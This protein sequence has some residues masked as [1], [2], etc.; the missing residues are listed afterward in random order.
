MSR[1][2]PLRG[3]DAGAEMSMQKWLL[4]E[5]IE[6]L[7]PG[8][9]ARVERLRRRILDLFFTHGYELV[10]PPMLEY[11]ESLLTGTGHDLD[12]KTF[13]LVDQLSGRLLGLRADITPQV[14]RIDAHLLNRQGVTRLCYAGT[15]LH[16]QPSGLLRTREPMQIG[17]ELYGHG[18]LESDIEI[19]ML[20]LRAL[21]A[22]GVEGV[23]LDIGHVSVFRSLITHAGVTAQQ[24]AELFQ[25]LQ[26]KDVP[27]LRD[28]SRGLDAPTRT[29]LLLLPDLYGGPE[30]LAMARERLPR[31]P[32]LT[33]CLD[34]LARL[35][36]ELRADV[37]ELCFDLAELRGYHYHS[38][39]VFAA[40]AGNQ[41]EAIARGGRYDEVGRAFGRARA[42]T[43]FTMD[44]R[45]LAQIGNSREQPMRV[46][47]PHRPEDAALQAE[48]AK[49]R[50]QGVVVVPD[51]PG[52]DT[53]R[54]ELDCTQELVEKNATWRLEKFD[55]T[56]QVKSMQGNER[57]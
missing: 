27:A 45:E 30:V 20:M 39:V 5:Y 38:G 37:N 31:Y 54:A 41:P 42:A 43:G 50:S 18:G 9:A 40:Y 4:P 2:E 53:S 24:E 7:L 33:A 51:L 57:S 21:Q 48:I 47:A 46:L 17:A 10:V 25:V 49:L 56:R 14:A 35:G 52:H 1:R 23:H 55:P 3:P 8:E 32:E 29:A 26:A 36:Q 15:V 22:T 16:T 13:K 34:A 44:L 28:L 6:D 12:L 19:Q 11:V